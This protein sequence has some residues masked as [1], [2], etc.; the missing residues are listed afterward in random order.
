VDNRLRAFDGIANELDVGHGA[1][2]HALGFDVT[3]MVEHRRDPDPEA[4]QVADDFSAQQ[5][6]GTGHQHVTGE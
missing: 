4:A 3:R 2:D 6:A 1:H 5:A